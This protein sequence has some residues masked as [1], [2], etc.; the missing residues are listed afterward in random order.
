MNII[1]NYYLQLDGI[2]IYG[3]RRDFVADDSRGS[4]PDL[5][6]HNP[7]PSM[8]NPPLKQPS[9]DILSKMAPREFPFIAMLFL[10]S[11]RLLLR[12]QVD[13]F[14]YDIGCFC[15]Y[16]T[17]LRLRAL[18]SW[19]YWYVL[20]WRLSSLWTREMVVG[21]PMLQVLVAII[22]VCSSCSSGRLNIPIIRST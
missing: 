15:I 1:F 12:L 13:C 17:T 4:V 21:S 20:W 10:L 2:V 19:C 8:L 6:T 11:L 9:G 3:C 16:F 14:I 18:A 7:A 5:H 22:V